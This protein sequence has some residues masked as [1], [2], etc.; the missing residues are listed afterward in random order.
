[1]VLNRR[2][3]RYQRGNENSQIEKVQKTQRKRTIGQTTI[4]KILQRKRM[5]EQHEPY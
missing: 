5:I 4:Y 3:W 2:V 1:M